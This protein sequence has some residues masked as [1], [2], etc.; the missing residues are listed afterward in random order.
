MSDY[1]GEW[2]AAKEKFE[3]TTGVKKPAPTKKNLF[4]KVV[5]QKVGIGEA[6]GAVDKLM[7][8][9]EGATMRQKDLDK[10]GALVSAAAQEVRDYLKLL[11]DAID[12]EK[13]EHGKGA[14]A[15]YR[16]LKIL[17]AELEAITAT[18]KGKLSWIYAERQAIS[19]G[20]EGGA[21]GYFK[22][23]QTMKS[24]IEKNS[25]KALV[26]VQDLLKDPTPQKF[27]AAFPKAARDLTQNIG[28]IHKFT[29]PEE[30][31][32]EDALKTKA[33]ALE[34]PQ[35][36]EAVIDL[37][38]RVEHF[39]LETIPLM[40]EEGDTPKNSTLARFCNS[41]IRLADNAPPEEVIAAAKNFGKQVKKAYELGQK[42]I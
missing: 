16:D 5:R 2:E 7:P 8:E 30:F 3:N 10:L 31:V 23:F 34:N 33:M 39:K 25:K 29:V 40:R 11:T 28:Q 27:N 26:V 18:M 12:K 19:K 4:G 14:D 42:I 22:M 38:K 13:E 36:V 17:K 9:D 15:I 21:K 35:I 6:F 41:P 37:N 24:N 20:I 32:N 1:Q